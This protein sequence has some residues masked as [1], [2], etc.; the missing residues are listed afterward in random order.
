MSKRRLSDLIE[1]ARGPSLAEI[2]ADLMDSMWDLPLSA[3]DLAEFLRL[4]GYD[5]IQ[6]QD[7]TDDDMCVL[8]PVLRTFLDKTTEQLLEIL[9]GLKTREWPPQQNTAVWLPCASESFRGA[10]QGIAYDRTLPGTHDP[11]AWIIGN[12][13]DAGCLLAFRPCQSAFRRG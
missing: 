5:D 8:I 10:F 12:A 9:D 3:F 1:I 6:R 13:K 2:F 7:L 4:V 11:P